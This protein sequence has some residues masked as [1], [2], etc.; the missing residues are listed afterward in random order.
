MPL[1]PRRLGDL[2]QHLLEGLQLPGGERARQG[3]VEAGL[4]TA[5]P[6]A[7]LLATLIAW[8]AAADR[9]GERVV[10]S[11]GLALAG[12][13]LLVAARLDGTAP[14][15]VAFLPAGAAGA[16]VHASSGRLILGWFAAHERGL[17]MGLRQTAQPLGVGVAALV[18]P[19]LAIAGALTFLGAFCWVAALLVVVFVRDPA[20]PG[21]AGPAEPTGSPY[22]TPF[23]W[24]IHAAS[25]LLIVPQFTVATFALV[26]LVEAHGWAPSEAGP[27]RCPQRHRDP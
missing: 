21:S 19:A 26:F 11:T 13:F 3:R 5:A 4:L 8:G 17:A 2:G 1:G 18:L 25:A 9:W 20:A 27:L 14:L 23:L 12:A 15:A 16:A 7:G 24:R 10:L 6:T 22:R